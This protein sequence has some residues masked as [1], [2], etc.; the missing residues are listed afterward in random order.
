MKDMRGIFTA[1]GFLLFALVYLGMTLTYPPEAR[2]FPMIVLTVMVI[3]CAFQLCVELLKRPAAAE[4]GEAEDFTGQDPVPEWRM[5]LYTALGVVMIWA[6]GLI[7]GLCVYL[8]FY[9]SFV[10]RLSWRKNL[11][12]TGGTAI[13]YYI[14]F[15]KVLK[16]FYRG[17]FGIFV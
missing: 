10:S 13:F 17:V 12:I 8:L 6:F 2:L 1:F 9:F 3:M 7:T 16:I 4:S 15:V 11:L 5:L 14:L